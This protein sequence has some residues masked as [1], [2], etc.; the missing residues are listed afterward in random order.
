MQKKKIN[1]KNAH[2]KFVKLILLNYKQSK[3]YYFYIF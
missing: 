1:K 2:Y 3:Q